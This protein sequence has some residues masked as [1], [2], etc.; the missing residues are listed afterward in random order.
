M[1]QWMK[2]REQGCGGNGDS[3]CADDEPER[4]RPR[5]RASEIT[6]PRA[7]EHRGADDHSMLGAVDPRVDLGDAISRRAHRDR[8]GECAGG[9]DPGQSAGA[10]ERGDALVA[11][12][13]L[14]TGIRGH[15]G[16]RP[17]QWRTPGSSHE[18]RARIHFGRDAPNLHPSLEAASGGFELR[19]AGEEQV[20]RLG[21]RVLLV[22]R[23]TGCVISEHQADEGDMGPRTTMGEAVDGSLTSA[24]A[25]REQMGP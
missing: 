6:Q 7:D 11:G 19:T 14:R 25:R 17:G 9:D 2:R 18:T 16:I 5:A 21:G 20:R 24:R 12:G 1:T 23:R 13:R 8:V 3:G 10:R 22:T 4:R 15:G